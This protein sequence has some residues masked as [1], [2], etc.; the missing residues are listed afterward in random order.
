MLWY[1][2]MNML[3]L[4]WMRIIILALMLFFL[5]PEGND[6]WVFAQQ[7]TITLFS[8]VE[9]D[10]LPEFDQPSMLI[11]STCELSQDVTLPADIVLRIPTAAGRP[12]LV[13]AGTSVDALYEVPYKIKPSGIWTYIILRSSLPIIRLE[14]YDPS[15]STNNLNRHYDYSWQ[16]DYTVENFY[17]QIQQPYGVSNIQIQPILENSEWTSD[18]VLRYYNIQI[19]KVDAG[20]E[21]SFSLDYKKE[22]GQPSTS[23]LQVHSSI[24][25]TTNTPG[26]ITIWNSV[27]WF[28]ILAFSIVLIIVGVLWLW[29]MN[30][31]KPV[32]NSLLRHNNAEK[33]KSSERKI[34]DKQSGDIH[35]FEEIHC[36]LC[37]KRASSGDQFCRSCGNRL[38]ERYENSY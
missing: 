26:R 30:L 11:V 37:G 7:K 8:S 27:P 1:D 23:S 6:N 2:K 14:Y 28:L 29:Q 3:L 5:I 35:P 22:G 12:S 10:L 20:R 18:G 13:A 16:S 24:P 9:V 32:I 17:L 33:R 36:N 4:R 31:R 38:R 34:E 25:I 21:I 19:G 15:F